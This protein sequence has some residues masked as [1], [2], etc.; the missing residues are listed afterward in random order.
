MFGSFRSVFLL[1]LSAGLTWGCG[2]ERLTTSHVPEAGDRTG[3]PLGKLA[4]NGMARAVVVARVQEGE[5]PVS[6][7]T[8]EFSRS[9]SGRAADFKWSG[10]T[11]A[12]GLARVEIEGTGYYRA[13]VMMDGSVLGSW[14]SIPING[15]YDVMLDLPI[16]GSARVTGSSLRGV[17]TIGEGEAVQIRTLLSHTVV[18]GLA[19]ASRYSIELA[20]RDFG[21]I[22][23]HEIELGLK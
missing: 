9:V 19:D 5:T 6:G 12:Q 23:G 22:H 13:R 1:A 20:V 11:D 17:V 7:V 15:D 3:Q 21:T 8:V 4:L 16:G 2:S 18:P 14:S 10:T